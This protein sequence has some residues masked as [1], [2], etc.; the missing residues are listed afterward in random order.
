MLRLDNSQQYCLIF[1]S[2]AVVLE[3]PNFDAQ[4]SYFA[5]SSHVSLYPLI[6]P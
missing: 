3:I 5:F 2:L 6:I 4:I 1:Q